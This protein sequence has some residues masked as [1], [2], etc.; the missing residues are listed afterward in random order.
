MSRL[1]GHTARKR[2]GQ[3]FLTDDRIIEHIVA[4]FGPEPGQSVV[5]IGPGLAALTRLLLPALG[6]L[7]VVELDRDLAQRLPKTLAGLGTLQVHQGDALQFDFR[8]LVAHDPAHRPLRLIGNLPYNISTP[9]IFHLLACADVVQDMTFM[10]QKEVVDRLCAEPDTADYGRLSVM[11]QYHAQADALFTVPPEAFTPPPKVTSAIVRLT[12]WV[13]KP[14]VCRDEAL[15]STVV[16][17]AFSMRRKTL[18]NALARYPAEALASS[19]VDLG[20]RA[21]TLAVADFVALTHALME[22]S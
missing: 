18:R 12:P 11:V 5:E 15:L 19:G 14:V 4:S 8:A 1:D 20:A 3:N 21:E 13:Q 2:F 10:L 9:L 16:T 17:A 22:A 7:Q 6:A